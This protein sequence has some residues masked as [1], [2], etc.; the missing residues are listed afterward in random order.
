[1]TKGLKIV[2]PSSVTD[3]GSL[4]KLEHY[5][6]IEFLRGASNGGGEHGYYKLIGDETLMSEMR[7]HNQIKIA[8]VKDAQIAYVLN[9]TNWSL[10]D[11]GA[12]SDLSGANGEDI[13][14]VH[15]NKVYAILGGTNATYE[16]FIVSDQPFSYDGDVAVEYTGFGETPDYETIKDGKARSIYDETVLGTQNDQNVQVLV[17]ETSGLGSNAARGGFPTTAI[18]RYGY[19]AY[20]R[21]KNSN[22]NNYAPYAPVNCFDIELAQAFM[23]IEFRTKQLQNYL[24]HGLSSNA[25]PDA[26]SWGKVTGVRYQ[27]T[28]DSNIYYATLGT[29][30]NAGGANIN[31][32]QLINGSSP[33]WKMFE[34]QRAV[35][36][37]ASFEAVKNSDGENVQGLGDGVMTGIYTK[38]FQIKANIAPANSSDASECTITY[39]FRIPVWRG[40]TRLWGHMA[41]WYSGYEVTK[42]NVGGTT[43]QTAYRAKS[44][45]GMVKDSSDVDF[46]YESAYDNLGQLVGGYAKNMLSIGGVS[47]A[48][49]A[50]TAAGVGRENYES[51][52][53]WM[54]TAAIADGVKVR[55]GSHFGGSARSA[56][57]VLRCASVTYAPSN[58][59]TILGSGFHVTLEND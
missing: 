55:K 28:G 56:S 10:T 41:Q 26:N 38:I 5:Y 34:A 53:V 48:L 27:W 29:Q 33:L 49:G 17:N 42:A 11:G 31:F 2:L 57:A 21:A 3:D 25:A 9:Q 40:R 50:D 22:T 52:G 47:T 15:T 23:F 45:E 59:Y 18:S 6:G 4:R 12:A 35:S 8:A 51:A 43:T 30:I 13:M 54:D 37:G 32:W 36:E 14:Q 7:F 24:G 44:I 1:M 16:R 58:A 39:C 19:E 46:S 20:A